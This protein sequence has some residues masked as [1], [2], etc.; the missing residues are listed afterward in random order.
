MPTRATQI[1]G[2]DGRLLRGESF[3]TQ[4]PELGTLKAAIHAPSC[5]FDLRT[6]MKS[7]VVMQHGARVSI[8]SDERNHREVDFSG[9]RFAANQ[10]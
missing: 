10:N 5:P 2:K 7:K 6:C 4:P 3:K 8:V 1:C 9:F